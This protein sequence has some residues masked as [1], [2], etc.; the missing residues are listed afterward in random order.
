[1]KAFVDFYADND[2]DIAEAAQFIPLNDDQRGAA[3]VSGGRTRL[4]RAASAVL[5][6]R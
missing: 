5:D 2:A 3:G 6:V 1:M 4:T